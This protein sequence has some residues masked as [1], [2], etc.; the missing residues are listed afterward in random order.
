MR[1]RKP[2]NA[3]YSC[4]RTDA[5]SGII[6]SRALESS[7]VDLAEEFS[8]LIMTQPIYDSAHLV[9]FLDASADFTRSYMS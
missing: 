1:K 9:R 2:E 3:A 4:S 5:H 7:T 6:K 8:N